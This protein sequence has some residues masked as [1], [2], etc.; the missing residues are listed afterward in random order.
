M[1][2][3]H[4]YEAGEVTTPMQSDPLCAVC[5]G[6]K[7]DV[8]HEWPSLPRETPYFGQADRARGVDPTFAAEAQTAY[9]NQFYGE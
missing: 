6:R 3:P 8:V 4:D 1:L 9:E 2:D 5:G 7:H